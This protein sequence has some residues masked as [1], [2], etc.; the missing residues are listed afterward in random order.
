MRD[1]SSSEPNLTSSLSVPSLRPRLFK[2]RV[3]RT[4]LSRAPASKSN[5]WP[6]AVLLVFMLVSALFWR[7]GTVSDLL[8]ASREQIFSQH[9]Y[10][11][12]LTTIGAHEDLVHFGSNALLFF[13]FGYLLNGYFGALAFPVLSLIFGVI[14]NLIVLYLYPEHSVLIGAS[15][16]VYWMAGF[17]ITLYGFVERSHSVAIRLLRMMGVALILLVPQEFQIH[18]SYLAHAVGFALGVF[19]G[20]VYFVLSRKEIRKADEWEILDAF[21]DPILFNELNHEENGDYKYGI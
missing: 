14:I 16:V 9:Q 7:G 1:G 2:M 20:S 12:L 8:S 18:V 17:W 21:G 11:R 19:A 4:L 15:G 13:I 10:W 6:V 5:R 3:K